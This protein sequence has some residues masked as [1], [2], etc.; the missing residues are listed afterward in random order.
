MKQQDQTFAAAIAAAP[1][2]IV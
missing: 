2:P 1:K